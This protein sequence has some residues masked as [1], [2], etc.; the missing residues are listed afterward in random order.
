MHQVAVTGLGIV[1]P[2]GIGVPAFLENMMNGATGIRPYD[3]GGQFDFRS[4]VLGQVAGFDARTS[5]LCADDL[6]TFDRYVL[7]ALAAAA[8]AM[9]DA[10]LDV[11]S[12][13]TDRLGVSIASAIAGTSAMEQDFITATKG[14]NAALNPMRLRRR[15]YSSANFA[16]AATLVAKR[17]DA[18]GPVLCQSTGCTAGLDAIGWGVDAI[19][20]GEADVV[21]AG[22]SEAPLTPI[23]VAA[24]EAITA[25]STR[26]CVDPSHASCPYSNER[27][28]FVLAEGCGI[29]VLE[30]MGRAKRRGA[31]IYGCVSGF[32]SVSNAYHMTDLAPEGIDL[33]RAIDMALQQA[34]AAPQRIGHVSAHGS[35]TPQNDVNET[36]ALK[37]VFGDRAK[38]IHVNS[39]KS[40]TGHA[41]AGANAVEMVAMALE[42][43]HGLI[44]PTINCRVPDPD[45]DLDYVTDGGRESRIDLALKIASGF[46]GIHSALVMERV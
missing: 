23:A 19:R 25:L 27:D 2:I 4:R 9:Q 36:N 42:V 44:H 43:Y 5:G 11:G 22:A 40:M 34:K 33:S 28:G 6:E 21:I 14:G 16:A 13:P 35:S 18:G 38:D 45:C 7:F 24:F 20:R 32:G 1:A 10:G 12:V 39:L 46:S 17:Y 8:E 37:R 31:R 3:W 15:A 29:V 30:R 41:L 26:E